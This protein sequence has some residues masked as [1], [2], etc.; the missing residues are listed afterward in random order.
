LSKHIRA[1]LTLEDL[2][3]ERCL[4]QPG[5][6]WESEPIAP[7]TLTWPPKIMKRAFELTRSLSSNEVGQPHVLLAIIDSYP[8][9]FIQLLGIDRNRCGTLREALDSAFREGG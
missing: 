6:R 7:K 4:E 8:V 3:I 2:R 1:L 9:P 5:V